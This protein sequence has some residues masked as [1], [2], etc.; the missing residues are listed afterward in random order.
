MGTHQEPGRHLLLKTE[1]NSRTPENAYKCMIPFR[2]KIGVVCSRCDPKPD[3]YCRILEKSMIRFPDKSLR[4]TGYDLG[5][6]KK[7]AIGWLKPMTGLLGHIIFPH[8]LF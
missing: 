5:P 8:S 7:F 4:L 3:K 6:D 1:S 2:I